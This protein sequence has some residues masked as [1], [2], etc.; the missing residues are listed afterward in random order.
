MALCQDEGAGTT[1]GA[2]ETPALRRLQSAPTE[3]GHTVP[4]EFDGRR[5][6]L[7]GLV[8][9][10]ML[11]NIVTLGFYRFWAKTRLR[12]YFWSNARI[13]SERFE[14]TGLAS[15]LF[16]GFLIVIAALTPALLLSAGVSAVGEGDLFLG[17]V[18]DV[19]YL[20]IFYALAQV[21]IYRAWRYRMSRTTWRAV[22]FGLD[23]SAWRFLG[24]AFMW[25]L[26]VIAT[27]G[28]AYPYLRIALVRYRVNHSRFGDGPFVFEGSGGDLI[29][30]WLRV[31]V[32]AVL[33]VVLG[34]VS[35]PLGTMMF[36]D[37]LAEPSILPPILSGVLIVVGL[38]LGY[39][40]YRVREF[41]YMVAH[42]RFGAA[43]F[44]SRA[45][46]RRVV[47]LALATGAAFLGVMA[48]V[49]VVVGIAGGAWLLADPFA[50]GFSIWHALAIVA[51]AAGLLAGPILTIVIFRFC[52][53][54]HL[55]RT[56]TITN[57]AVVDRVVQSA[58]KGP[59]RGEGLADAIDVGTF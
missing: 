16:L 50:A 42:T 25:S 18:L 4:V 30:S 29:G 32:L 17:S 41:R 1:A 54:R 31:F 24:L 35:S 33:A 20:A 58:D 27:L 13:G 2:L 12:R 8:V 26:V 5:A 48:V 3:T 38:P 14:Y 43:T 11:L 37:G 28:V 6:P 22:R 49:A 7:L 53:V 40:W 19:A 44:Q 34:V 9:T 56:L 51:I 15:E 52:L 46:A 21:A 39:V 57:I 36:T 45:Q 23:G 10:N 47:G 59:K 55:C